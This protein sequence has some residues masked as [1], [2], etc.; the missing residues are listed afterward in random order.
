M[1]DLKTE[2]MVICDYANVS[3][4]GKLNINGIFDEI[5]V[6]SFPGGIARAF[7]VAT[8]NGTPNTNYSLNLRVKNPTKGKNP[9]DNFALETMTGANGKNNMIVE[10]INLGFENSG[11]Y[12]VELYQDKK[13]IGSKT[14]K[15][16][17]VGKKEEKFRIVN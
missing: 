7:L 17:E 1:K 2:L 6:Q 10:L 15:V 12:E 5:W 8:I 4:E 3:R 11:D 13:V 9:I 16:G 14:L